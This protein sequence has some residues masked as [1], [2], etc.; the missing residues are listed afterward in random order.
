MVAA[1]DSVIRAL[2]LIAAP[3]ERGRQI[4]GAQQ[5]MLVGGDVTLTPAGRDEALARAARVT[6]SLAA[7]PG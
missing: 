7:V 1:M 4:I 6:D 5:R 2:V 3:A